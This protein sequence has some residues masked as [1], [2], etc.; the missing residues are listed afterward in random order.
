MNFN[1]AII[2][3]RLTREPEVR[4]L[5]SG[6]PVTN[7]SLATNH[8]YKTK[9]GQKVEEVLFMEC[10]AFGRTA[11]VMVQYAVKGQ[12][13]MVAGRLRQEEWTDK[14][15]NARKTIRLVVD[16][17]QLGQKPMGEGGNVAAPKPKR[18]DAPPIPDEDIPF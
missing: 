13:L 2:A 12:I 18:D 14:D 5:P 8:T 17:M 9:D 1:Q 15:G 4:Q 16:T 11:E 10:T 6:A 3:G 7:F